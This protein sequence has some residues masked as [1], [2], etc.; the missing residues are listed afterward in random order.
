VYY[1]R[2]RGGLWRKGDT[3]GAVQV[4]Q[5]HGL[6]MPRWPMFC[7]GRWLGMLTEALVCVCVCVCVC[8]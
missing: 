3:S 7:R 6:G 2:S 4:G 5:G 8:V 1:S